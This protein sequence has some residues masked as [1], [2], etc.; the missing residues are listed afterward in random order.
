MSDWSGIAGPLHE[1]LTYRNTFYHQDPVIDILDPRSGPDG[2]YDFIVASEVFEH[3]PPPVQGGFDNL[4]RLLKPNGFVIFSTPWD[5]D[6]HTREYY[7][8]LY[9]WKIV[10][11]RGGCV[12]VNKTTD[13]QIQT[14]EDLVFHGGPGE[15]LEMRLFSKND[16]IDH[17]RKAHF[18]EIEISTVA[19]SPECGIIWEPWSRGMIARKVG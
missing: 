11:L 4:A 2:T 19:P 6:G 9:D 16:L 10:T 15:T 5:P 17:F 3:L 12:L 14:F 8:T 1:K 7:P 18:E 13:G